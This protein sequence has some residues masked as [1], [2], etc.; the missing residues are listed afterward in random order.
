MDKPAGRFS[1]LRSETG[2]TVR[3]RLIIA[4]DAVLLVVVEGRVVA[5]G[6]RGEDSV[7]PTPTRVSVGINP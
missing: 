4:V 6:E 2:Q 3:K 7:N 1:W 5:E